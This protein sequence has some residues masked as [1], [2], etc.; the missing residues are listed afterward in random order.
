MPAVAENYRSVS[1]TPKTPSG[2]GA[3]ARRRDAYTGAMM[4]W[5]GMAA[6][7]LC[8]ALAGYALWLWREVWRRRAGLRARRDEAGAHRRDSIRILARAVID[9]ELNLT[10]GAIRLKVL[11]DHEVPAETGAQRFPAIY[12]LHDAT[13]H[14][15]RR[16]ER[17]RRPRSEI[18]RL[19]AEREELETDYRQAV[20]AEA[21][22]LL[23]VADSDAGGDWLRRGLH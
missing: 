15:P 18:A 4:V 12:G 13:A 22:R 16:L 8:L 11:L 17:R 1:K 10:E 23:A 3:S 21:R 2:K 6:G 5:I 19:D 9:D 20:L 7:A 14:M